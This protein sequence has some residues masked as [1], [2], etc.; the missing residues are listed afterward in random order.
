MQTIKCVHV[1]IHQHSSGAITSQVC[2]TNSN[3]Y[4]LHLFS[5]CLLRDSLHL[6]F[7]FFLDNGQ[8]IKERE[9]PS[10]TAVSLKPVREQK[11]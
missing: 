6:Q 8:A 7:I 11:A 4:H 2:H 10:G 5:H 9:L 1:C 3:N